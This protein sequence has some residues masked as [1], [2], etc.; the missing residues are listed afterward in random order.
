MMC[1]GAQISRYEEQSSQTL[2]RPQQVVATGT[3][4]AINDIF[5]RDG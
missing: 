2:N 1:P 4:V 3:N 5:N